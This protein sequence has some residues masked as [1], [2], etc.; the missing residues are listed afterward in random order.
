[1][2]ILVACEV[3]GVVRDAFRAKG[4]DAYSCDILP[5]DSLYHIQ[6]DALTVINDG[7]DM[8]VCHPPCTDLAVSGARWFKEKIADGRQQAAIDFALRLWQAPIPLIALENPVSVLASHIRPADQVVH[9]WMFGQPYS[10]AT[11]L[12][13]KGLSPLQPTNVVDKGSRR[14]YKSGASLPSWYSDLPSGPGRAAA[15]SKTFAGIALAM[16]EQWGAETTALQQ[17]LSFT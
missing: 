8:M 13:L 1:M 16:S 2:K 10:K 17:Q 6:R 4:H 5:S 3:S 7:W 12:W 14:T 15:R 11:C 9:P